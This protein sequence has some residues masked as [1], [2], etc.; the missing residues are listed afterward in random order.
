M[1]GMGIAQYNADLQS[2]YITIQGETAMN[3]AVL[4]ERVAE[5]LDLMVSASAGKPSHCAEGNYLPTP[6]PS[7]PVDDLL[8]NLRLQ[9]RYLMFDLEAT[10]RES[11]YLRQ[12]LESRSRRPENDQDQDH[13]PMP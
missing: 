13:P 10:R 11:K 9:V 6:S 7:Q 12:M 8:V 1:R 3:E 4:K 5:M 2:H